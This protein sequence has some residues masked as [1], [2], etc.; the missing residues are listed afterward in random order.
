[1][2]CCRVFVVLTSHS[3]V[4]IFVLCVAIVFYVYTT[5]HRVLGCTLMD[6]CLSYTFFLKS[7]NPL[8]MANIP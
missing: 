6:N 2:L 4:F 7:A 8:K 1:M 5:S 3:I